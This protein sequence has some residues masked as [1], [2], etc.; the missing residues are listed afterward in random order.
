MIIGSTPILVLSMSIHVGQDQGTYSRAVHWWCNVSTTTPSFGVSI[1]STKPYQALDR[2]CGFYCRQYI[3]RFRLRS[4]VIGTG[5]LIYELMLVHAKSAR[6][7]GL[8]DVPL[9]DDNREIQRNL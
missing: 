4:K 2:S 9:R 3:S 8:V 7:C 5:A 1:E 6:N